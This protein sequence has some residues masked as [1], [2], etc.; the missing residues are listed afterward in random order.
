MAGTREVEAAVLSVVRPAVAAQRAPTVPVAPPV[1]AAEVRVAV[2]ARVAVVAEDEQT[3][4]IP[5]I[6]GEETNEITDI[7]YWHSND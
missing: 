5:L 1:S 7:G 6:Q 2:A 3:H 4:T